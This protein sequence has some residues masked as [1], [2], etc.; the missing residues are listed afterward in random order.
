M[1]D[2]H[3]EIKRELPCH[4]YCRPVSVI[5]SLPSPIVRS[6]SPLCTIQWD[7]SSYFQLFCYVHDL[8]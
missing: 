8:K 6:V 5:I 2:S 3:L 1:C 7:K 4:A